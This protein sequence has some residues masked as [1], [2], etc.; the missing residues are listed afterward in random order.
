MCE[1]HDSLKQKR[2]RSDG[3]G[4]PMT[5]AIQPYSAREYGSK[6]A[7]GGNYTK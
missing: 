6:A 4:Q 3:N 7:E 2:F 5:I 1:I